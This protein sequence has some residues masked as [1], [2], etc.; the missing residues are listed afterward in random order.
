VVDFTYQL[1]IENFGPEA[2]QVRL[3]DRMPT[4][5]ENEVKL[6]LVA[7]GQPLS[8]DTRYEQQQRK[9]GVLR[10]DVKVPAQ[11]IAAKAF[12]L[13]YQMQMEYDKQLSIAGLPAR[14]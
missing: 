3:L 6:S 14:R 8:E 1:S 11:A 7:P 5:K 9:K 12:T 4:G 13:D 2:A 10:W